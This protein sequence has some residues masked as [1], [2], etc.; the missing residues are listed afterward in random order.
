MWSKHQQDRGL[1]S[2]WEHRF[3]VGRLHVRKAGQCGRKWSVFPYLPVGTSHGG[4]L[5]FKG[6]L[7]SGL[8]NVCI[9]VCPCVLVQAFVCLCFV[10]SDFKSLS[11]ARGRELGRR[12]ALSI[13]L[14]R[15]WAKTVFK[16]S[17][18]KLRVQMI[19]M[20]LLSPVLASSTDYCVFLG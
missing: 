15:V 20:F 3:F 11:F 18:N 6:D 8:M 19:L 9:C 2:L 5:D 4:S 12:L 16:T 17:P 1:H 10:K 14:L 7:V 13:S